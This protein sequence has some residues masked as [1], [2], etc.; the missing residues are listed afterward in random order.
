MLHSIVQV[1]AF[2]D[3][4]FTGNPAA[5]CL[6]DQPTQERWMQQVAREM[7]LSETA[8]LH[9]EG[10]GYRLRWFTPVVEV[11]L[12][13]HATLASAHVLYETGVLAATTT[14]RFYTRSGELRATKEGN[15][16]TLDFPSRP[17]TPQRAPFDI[18]AALG[19][20]VL[21]IAG[22]SY[23]RWLAEIASEAQLRTLKPDFSR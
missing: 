11:P 21:Q 12:C 22:N 18:A 6:L 20:P 7:N 1:D 3:T 8:F 15:W 19:V 4:P 14:A 10:D 23:K 2:T 16:V 5:V 9:P 17:M 13:G